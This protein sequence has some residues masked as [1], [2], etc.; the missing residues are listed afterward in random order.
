MAQFGPDDWAA[1]GVM[2]GYMQ[3]QGHLQVLSALIDHDAS[4]Q[5]A[6]DWPRWRYQ[7]DGTLAVET[8]FDNR[9]AV[10]LV[11][12]GH[13][14]AVEAPAAFGGGQIVRALDGVLSG[15]TDPRKDGAVSG[16]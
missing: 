5:E 12:R 13:D 4:L 11:R 8:R 2:G 7:S 16:F 15:A 1:F 6:L 9:L 10:K 3:P 14:V